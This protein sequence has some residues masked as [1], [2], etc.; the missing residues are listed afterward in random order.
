MG[1]RCSA[2]GSLHGRHHQ[3]STTRVSLGRQKGVM[4]IKFIF[5]EKN[6]VNTFFLRSLSLRVITP[7]HLLSPFPPLLRL[8]VA[9]VVVT[10]DPPGGAGVVDSSL[11]GGVVGGVC[12]AGV[13]GSGSV[14]PNMENK[15]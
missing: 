5:L 9:S 14:L 10:T 4:S 11:V 6:V 12:G 15:T 2:Q 8:I 1:A 13:S 7:L 3:K